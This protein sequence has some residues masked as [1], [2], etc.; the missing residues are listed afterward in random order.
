[1]L[2]KIIT[3]KIVAKIIT[4]NN[5]KKN[6]QPD[7]GSRHNSGLG[8]HQRKEAGLQGP[9]EGPEPERGLPSSRDSPAEGDCDWL[10]QIT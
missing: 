8:L 6:P 4:K 10:T 9:G 7:R 5:H 2:G 3:K 1:M